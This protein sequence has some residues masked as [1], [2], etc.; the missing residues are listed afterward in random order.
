MALREPNLRLRFTALFAAL[1]VLALGMISAS[2]HLHERLHR[3]DAHH[4]ETPVGAVDHVCAVT[5]FAEGLLVL[6]FFCFLLP[7]APVV[8]S[9]AIRAVDETVATVP[10]YRLVPSHAPPSA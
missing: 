4:H 8:R 6:A 10:R 9:G 2:P 1:C 3:G 5:L 7:L